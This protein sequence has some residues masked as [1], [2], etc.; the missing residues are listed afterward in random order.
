LDSHLLIYRSQ[1]TQ[2]SE[3]NMEGGTSEFDFAGYL[4]GSFYHD[5]IDCACE[6]S[7]I[8]IFVVLYSLYNVEYGSEKIGELG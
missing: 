1:Y 2:L 3:S 6:S 7:W 4:S 8:D 5:Y